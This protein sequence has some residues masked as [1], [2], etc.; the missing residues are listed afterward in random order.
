[1]NESRFRIERRKINRFIIVISGNI[2][3]NDVGVMRLMLDTE[4]YLLLN[5][6]IGSAACAAQRVNEIL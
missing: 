6:V 1:M 4:C 3:N 5:V 2:K